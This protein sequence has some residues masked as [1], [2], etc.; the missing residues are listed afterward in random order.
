VVKIKVK[1]TIKDG[2]SRIS[3]SQNQGKDLPAKPSDW[4][5]LALEPEP[6]FRFE[7]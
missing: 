1:G 5:G 6:A 7:F 2:L 3:N 4:P